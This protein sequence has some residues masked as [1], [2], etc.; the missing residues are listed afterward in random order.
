MT[1]EM[2]PQIA[3]ALRERLI[4]KSSFDLIRMLYTRK[5]EAMPQNYYDF[6]KYQAGK[7]LETRDDRDEAKKQFDVA[8]AQVE[9]AKAAR[10]LKH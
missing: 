4:R 6:I 5:A 1:L 2:T 8:A 9:M 3:Q 7:I 10:M